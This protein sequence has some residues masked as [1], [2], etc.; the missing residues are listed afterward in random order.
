VHLHNKSH[1]DL[2]RQLWLKKDSSSKLCHDFYLLLSLTKHH[3]TQK[4]PHA[5]LPCFL[6]FLKPVPMLRLKMHWRWW[7]S[8]IWTSKD[9]TVNYYR[10][11]RPNPTSHLKILTS[12]MASFVP[13]WTNI[14]KKLWLSRAL[15]NGQK[16]LLFEPA[17]VHKRTWQPAR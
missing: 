2:L 11:L 9:S 7:V 4:N 6:G 8:L 17:W 14:A 3:R 13:I 16:Q 10:T 15:Q 5:V 12:E 1:F